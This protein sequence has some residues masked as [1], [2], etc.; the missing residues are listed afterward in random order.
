MLNLDTK[1]INKG[2]IEDNKTIFF[3]ITNEGYLDYTKN[4]LESLKQFNCDKNVLIVCIDN[5]S[6]EYFKS[7]GYFTHFIDLNFKEFSEF[8]TEGFIKCC[9]L[10]L[11]L[12]NKFINLGYNI[13]Y[14][15]GD[16]FY[17]K[18]PIDELN[19]YREINGDMWIQN[20]T[21][22]DNNF[23]NVCAGFLY[24]RANSKTKLYFDIDIPE[25]SY[26]YNE[27][28]KYNNDQTYINNFII[29]HLNV[30]LFPLNK[31]PNGNYFYNFNRNIKDSIIMVHFN[32]IVGHEK[33]EQMKK[34]GMWII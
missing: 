34:Y 15:D 23:N 1:Y 32:W 11:F 25:F 33:K 17:K 3:T 10:K 6:N 16:I 5:I 29:P 22:Y 12:I 26:R 27:C 30:H 2:L 4:M 20:D 24:I 19:T 28:I 9:Y 7:K 13:F 8:G 18:N 14:S 31:F 21:I